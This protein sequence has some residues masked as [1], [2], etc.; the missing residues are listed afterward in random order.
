MGVLKNPL[1]VR[2]VVGMLAEN[3]E[4]A[5]EATKK[6]EERFGVVD[7]EMPPVPFAHTNYYKDELGENPFKSFVAFEERINRESIKDIKIETNEMEKIWNRRV[8][9]D[10]GY[11]TLGQFFLAT[12]KDQRHRV[13]LGGGIFAEVTLYFEDG[14][15]HP[16]DW[17]YPDYRSES[18]IKF[19]EKA[20]ERL[21]YQIAT[22]KPYSKR[23]KSDRSV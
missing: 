13:Y 6:L 7:L 20:R 9:L 16:F 3:L 11:M 14:H 22:G 4:L 10:P 21:A 12:T 15:F 18:Y 8:N 19:L 17:T 5:Q 2:L 1:P 23:G